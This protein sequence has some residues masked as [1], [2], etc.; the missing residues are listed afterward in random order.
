MHL[1]SKQSAPAAVEGLLFGSYELSG[2]Q[3]ISLIMTGSHTFNQ[4]IISLT[5]HSRQILLLS[6]LWKSTKGLNRCKH[7][8]ANKILLLDVDAWVNAKFHRRREFV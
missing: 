6:V 8:S 7:R 1:P 5:I 2:S 4:F 3:N